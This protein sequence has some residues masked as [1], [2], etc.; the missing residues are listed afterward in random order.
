VITLLLTN[1]LSLSFLGF[2]LSVFVASF[3]FCPTTNPEP[4]GI[5]S[6]PPFYLQYF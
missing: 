3:G 4:V 2:A 6:P 5:F 1:S